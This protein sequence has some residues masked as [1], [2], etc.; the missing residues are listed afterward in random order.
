MEYIRITIIEF[1]DEYF[2]KNKKTVELYKNLSAKE[3]GGRIFD[4]HTKFDK[5]L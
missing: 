3:R 5:Q 4:M 1:Q 2:S